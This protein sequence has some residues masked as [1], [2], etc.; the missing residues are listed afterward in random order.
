MLKLLKM[1]DVENTDAGNDNSDAA[2]VNAEC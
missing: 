1:L 2:A